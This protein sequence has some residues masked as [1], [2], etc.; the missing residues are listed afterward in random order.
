MNIKNSKIKSYGWDY[1]LDL[2]IAKEFINNNLI[3]KKEQYCSFLYKFSFEVD[4]LTVRAGFLKKI[5][6]SNLTVD[7][8]SVLLSIIYSTAQTHEIAYMKDDLAIL[9]KECLLS[10]KEQKLL[11]FVVASDWGKFFFL[12]ESDQK[13]ILLLILS[14]KRYENSDEICVFLI[15]LASQP[16]TRSFILNY[17]SEEEY[18]SLYCHLFNKSIGR[19]GGLIKQTAF[20]LR[21]EDILDSSSVEFPTNMLISFI[22]DRALDEVCIFSIVSIASRI[23]YVCLPDVLSKLKVISETS[24]RYC[25]YTLAP[26]YLIWFKIQKM[27]LDSENIPFND[28]AIKQNSLNDFYQELLAAPPQKTYNKLKE[29][30]GV[31]ITTYNPE[32]NK[33]EVAVKSILQQTYTNIELILVDDCSYEENS[34]NIASL[35]MS[36]ND[37]RIKL[38]KNSVNRGQYISRNTAI[39][40]NPS[41]DYF[42]IQDDDD[43]SHPNRLAEQLALLKSSSKL[44]LVMCMQARFTEEM[45]YVPDK[46][47]PIQFDRSPATSLFKKETYINVGGF[48]DV[49]TRGDTEYINR[50][51][52]Q[53]GINSIGAVNVPLYLMRCAPETIS[54]SKDRTLKTQLDV[55]RLRMSEATRSLNPYCDTPWALRK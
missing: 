34:K 52:K 36:L 40:E 29:K 18:F 2:D 26:P 4:D 6:E 22:K 51:K 46:V 33:L 17:L 43:F 48:A 53:Y 13:E 31:L 25:L 39:E 14:N 32:I 10:T 41:C 55:F 44:K 5:M 37:N 3:D 20:L 35:V 42:A 16:N 9:M 30:I 19:T 45:Y 38:I 23:A 28:M 8:K 47:N 1:I 7:I 21:R 11:D 54:S 15:K 27:C 12:Q 24:V 49:R 50:I